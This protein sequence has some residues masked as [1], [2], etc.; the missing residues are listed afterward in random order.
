[1]EKK[2]VIAVGIALQTQVLKTCPV[3]HQLYFDDDVNPAS[4]FALAIELVRNHKPYVE[5]FHDDE[6]ALTDLLSDTLSTTPVCCPECRSAAMLD[7][8]R[9]RGGFAE[10]ALEIR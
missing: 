10:R 3:H 1:M 9:D 5:E 4:A 8:L 2:Q 6:H 7:S